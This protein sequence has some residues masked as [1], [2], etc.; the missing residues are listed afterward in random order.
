MEKLF[1]QLKEASTKNDIIEIAKLVTEIN[2]IVHGN[3]LTIGHKMT[4]QNLRLIT[5]N[6]SLKNA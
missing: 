4:K 6:R 1:K 3:L 5:L 2:A